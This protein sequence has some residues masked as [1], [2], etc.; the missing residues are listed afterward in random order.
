MEL[1]EAQQKLA[2]GGGGSV[3]A[4]DGEETVKL[5]RQVDEQRKQLEDMRRSG[6]QRAKMIEDR[7]KSLDE[8]DRMFKKRKEMLDQMEAKIKSVNYF[9]NC[10]HLYL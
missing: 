4:K 1:Q 10:Y 7:Q 5:R 3:Q 2:S 6:E 9:I 8:T